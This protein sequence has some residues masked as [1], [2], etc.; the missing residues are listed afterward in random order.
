MK[1]AAVAALLLSAAL[2]APASAAPVS[3]APGSA[4]AVAKSTPT[5][6]GA[7]AFKR[8]QS[9]IKVVL[10]E[11]NDFPI[12][13]AGAL[14][15]AYDPKVMDPDRPGIDEGYT[16]GVDLRLEKRLP[17]DARAFVAAGSHL[18][19]K[20]TGA[21]I[22][23]TAAGNPIKSVHFTE[24]NVLAAGVDALER[25]KGPLWKA[26]AGVR[27]LESDRIHGWGASGQQ[28]AFHQTFTA[29]GQQPEYVYVPDGRPSRTTAFVDVAAGGAAV[30]AQSGPRSA[31]LRGYV[32][33]RLFTD[34]RE[35][36]VKLRAEIEGRIDGSKARAWAVVG[37]EAL[38]HR[39]GLEIAP[40]LKLVYERLKW[41]AESAIRFPFGTLDN[42]AG[43]N[44]SQT[45]ISSLSIYAFI[46]RAKTVNK[47]QEEPQ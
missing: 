43:Y 38:G 32:E 25:V 28:K 10:Q 2:A 16:H 37:A 39:E 44:W 15:Y 26:A 24:E 42:A 46:G 47:R 4:P 41:G 45:P 27:F 20:E 29:Q 5:P 9:S 40:T 33:P 1:K 13:P 3:A 36:T 19:T 6:L 30:V 21:A 18:Y 35:S 12:F 17:S 8:V 7:A 34:P 23:H 22:G 31:I 14:A 11:N